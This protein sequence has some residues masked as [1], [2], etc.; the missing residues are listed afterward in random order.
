MSQL[1]AHRGQKISFP[2]NTLEAITAAI[3]CGATAVEFD[4]QLTADL[5]P[6]ICHDISLARTA[7]IDI[8]IAESCYEDINGINVGEPAR[9]GDQYLSSTL[10]SLQAMVELLQKTPQV[11]AFI[12]LKKES[13]DIFGVDTFITP[14]LELLESIR[15]QCVIIS[16]NLQ[17][18]LLFRKR[19]SLP[20]GWIVHRWHDEDLARAKEC[21]IDYL[22]MN[23]K[24]YDAV[25]EHDFS[26]DN[27]HWMFYEANT[28]EMVHSLFSLG[29][30]FVET[31][32]ICSIL[33]SV[34]KAQS[35]EHYE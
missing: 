8:D 27:W 26:A 32:D 24:Y 3:N 1:V 21:N 9:F 2:E 31:E 7:G 10:P 22:V 18:L 12:E 13:L 30:D 5:V 4:V 6:V 11:T 15:Q 29:I 16:D 19:S 28:P 20:I 35:E 33:R 17:A 14:V 34:D 23:H 25:A